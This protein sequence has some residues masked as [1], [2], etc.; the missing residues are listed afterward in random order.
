MRRPTTWTMT[1]VVGI[2]L[3]LLAGPAWGQEGEEPPPH[4]WCGTTPRWQWEQAGVALDVET[5]C[6]TFETCDQPL[7]RDDFLPVEG[8]PEHEVA[9]QIN[10]LCSDDGSFCHAHHTRVQ[11]AVAQLEDDFE[12][13]DFGPL[14]EGTKIRFRYRLRFIYDSRFLVLT[15]AGVPFDDF[16]MRDLY[17]TSPETLLNV[18]VTDIL[19]NSQF[20]GLGT[21]PWSPFAL[22]PRGGV[23]VDASVFGDPFSGTFAHEVG[24]ALGLWHTHRGGDTFETP[25]CSACWEGVHSSTD[26]ASN[27]VGDFCQDTPATNPNFLCSLPRGNDVCT[28]FVNWAWLGAR[29]RNFMGFA[30]FNESGCRINF[31]AQQAARMRCY[32]NVRLAGWLVDQKDACLEARNTEPGTYF[33]TTRGY[34]PSVSLSACD[35]TNSF[36]DAWYR[37]DAI[38]SGPVTLSF[39]GSGTSLDTSVSVHDS[40]AAQPQPEL[41]C[42]NGYPACGQFDQHARLTFQA[43]AGESY[44]IRV[45]GESGVGDYTMLLCEG[46][47]SECDPPRRIKVKPGPGTPGDGGTVTP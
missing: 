38:A 21:Y 27:F 46:T 41:T 23:I 28:M 5:G 31:T 29:P 30:P 24:H 6:P 35:Q 12:A 26:F 34:A 32:L 4:G 45:T 8:A 3:A 18:W 11:D 43:V 13:L 17:A 19:T 47:N 2:A 7:R 22:T 14:D 42:S 40:C 9:L 39:C 1:L 33:G 15:L 16:V 44:F 37:Y 25:L 36:P 20:R 10:V